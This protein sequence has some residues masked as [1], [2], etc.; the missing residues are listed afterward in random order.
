M[1]RLFKSFK[2]CERGNIFSGVGSKWVS[3]KVPVP[4]T[5][6]FVERILY[7]NKEPIAERVGWVIGGRVA[8]NFLFV[9]FSTR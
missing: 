6:R 1:K 4:Q 9:I 7:V 5:T 8:M 3:V 2:R